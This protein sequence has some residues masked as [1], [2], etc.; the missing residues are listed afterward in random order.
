MMLLKIIVTLK[1]LAYFFI[2]C[3]VFLLWTSASLHML[4]I[5]FLKKK[6]EL[7]FS[8]SPALALSLIHI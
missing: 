1:Y 8:G 6:G 2:C 3:L 5:F 4:A 7:G